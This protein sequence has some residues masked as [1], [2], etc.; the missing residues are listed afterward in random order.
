MKTIHCHV[1]VPTKSF[2]QDYWLGLGLAAGIGL[3]ILSGG[4]HTFGHDASAPAGTLKHLIMEGEA[5]SKGYN[6]YNRGSMR[7]AKGNRQNLQL[8]NMSIQQI[9]YY[10]S[11]PACTPNKLLAVGHYQMVPETLNRAVRTLNIPRSTRFTPQV[12]DT[13][14]ALYLAKEKQPAIRRWICGGQNIKQ[15]AHAVAGEWAIFKTPYTNRGVYHGLGSNKA[16]I[17]SHRVIRALMRA[18]QH[19]YT[20]TKTGMPADKAYAMALGVAP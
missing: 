18:R 4:F 6:S 9:Q 16:R 17:G 20:L 14:F 1:A 19:Y 13:I 10:Q 11:L 8:T 12:Q 15:A 3:S 5:G 2:W 7:C